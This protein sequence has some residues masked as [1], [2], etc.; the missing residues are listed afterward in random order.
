[1]RVPQKKVHL[2]YLEILDSAQVDIID[3]ENTYHADPVS[4]LELYELITETTGNLFALAF[5]A[6]QERTVIVDVD[7]NL[8]LLTHKFLGLDANDENMESFR[9]LNNI[10]ND[11]LF[12]VKKGRTIKYFV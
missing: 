2:K 7:T 5:D 6:K 11:E 8:V 1:M 12:K 4:Q 3:V 10:K 9:E